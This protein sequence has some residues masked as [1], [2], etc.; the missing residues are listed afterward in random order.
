MISGGVTILTVLSC[1]YL[2]TS[3]VSCINQFCYA[4][5]LKVQYRI[6]FTAR[7]LSVR[8]DSFIIYTYLK[9]NLNLQRVYDFHAYGG[10]EL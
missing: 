1:V 8:T 4:S 9:K 6:Y 7:K 5:A 10:A 2:T 3:P